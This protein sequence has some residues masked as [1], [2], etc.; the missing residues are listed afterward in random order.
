[1]KTADVQDRR[2]GVAVPDAVCPLVIVLA[3]LVLV[4]AHRFTLCPSSPGHSESGTG[5]RLDETPQ[6]ALRVTAAGIEEAA[7]DPADRRASVGLARV[8]I[9]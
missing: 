7:G 2:S 1:M 3:L 8:P 4:R 5:L 6:W 9:R